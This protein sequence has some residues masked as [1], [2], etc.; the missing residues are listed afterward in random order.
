MSISARS[1]LGGV[2]HFKFTPLLGYFVELGL[3]IGVLMAVVQTFARSAGTS[4]VEAPRRPP[5][6][7]AVR[8]Q[9]RAAGRKAKKQRRE[10]LFDGVT[11]KDHSADKQ[12]N[13]SS[14]DP[15]PS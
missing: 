13:S 11:S 10:H 15:S 3:W 4:D 7:R 2:V 1:S 5:A 9:R 6:T 8:S 14:D 12:R